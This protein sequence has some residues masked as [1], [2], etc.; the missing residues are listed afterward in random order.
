MI[1]IGGGEDAVN[2][3]LLTTSGETVTLTCSLE[4]LDGDDDDN[5]VTFTWARQ[6][7]RPL[8]EGSSQNEGEVIYQGY[9]ACDSILESSK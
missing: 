4:Q 1:M 3:T 9:C 6:D 7:G 2:N 8:P 5:P